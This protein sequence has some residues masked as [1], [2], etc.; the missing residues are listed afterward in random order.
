MS[1]ILKKENLLPQMK[2]SVSSKARTNSCLDHL[3]TFTGEIDIE[4]GPALWIEISGNE[5]C[6]KDK[7][8]I[9]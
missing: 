2:T 9:R 1:N 6:V 4:S 7:N 8:K 5:L 3:C